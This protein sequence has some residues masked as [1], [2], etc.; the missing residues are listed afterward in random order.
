MFKSAISELSELI[1]A[2]PRNMRLTLTDSSAG[3]WLL[4]LR[5]LSIGGLLDSNVLQAFD[6]PP[7]VTGLTFD[8]S[9]NPNEEILETALCSQELL[10][11]SV[12]SLHIHWDVLPYLFP[13][14]SGLL[15]QLPKLVSLW[16]SIESTMWFL[17]NDPT[18]GNMGLPIRTL[19]LVGYWEYQVTRVGR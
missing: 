11:T 15:Y 4:R 6:G 5:Q 12:K 18:P 8:W 7:A 10:R 9:P 3:G 13:D 14:G 1:L 16:A 17:M 19:E 2:L